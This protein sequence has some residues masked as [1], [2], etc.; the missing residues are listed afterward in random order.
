MPCIIYT[1][2]YIFVSLTL[3]WSGRNLQQFYKNNIIIIIF[4]MKYLC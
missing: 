1:I 3:K 2:I 4:V